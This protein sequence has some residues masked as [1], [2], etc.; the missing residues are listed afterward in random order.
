MNTSKLFQD[1]EREAG[2]LTAEDVCLQRGPRRVL[3]GIHVT[4][5][6]GR[7]L[8]LVGPNGAGK[9]SLLSVLAGLVAPS[10]GRVMLDGHPLGDWPAP[11]LARRRAMLS[12]TVRA[13]FGFS[14]L[15]MVMLGRSS[16]AGLRDDPGDRRIAEAALRATR[17]WHLRDRNC[18]HLSGGEQRRVQLARVL[19]Q[20]WEPPPGE[21]A[22]LLLDE[23]EAGLDIAHQ[24]AVLQLARRLARRGYGVIT[25]LHDLNLAACYADAVALLAQGRLLRLGP[26]GHALDPQTL[27]S[28]YGIG[29][30]RT[31][32][33]ADGTSWIVASG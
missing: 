29:M 20:V 8:A 13:G 5:H 16:H 30:R 10:H 6:P 17:A 2:L 14:A 24:H 27:S 22:W 26:P 9:S 33:D 32:P 21:P 3:D 18:L 12:Q 15:E 23:P 1:I 25:V 31:A 7:L 19:A 28:V 4:A 11:T